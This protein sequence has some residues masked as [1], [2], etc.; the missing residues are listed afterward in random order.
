MFFG[1]SGTSFAMCFVI[2]GEG[3]L[4]GVHLIFFNFSIFDVVLYII[5]VYVYRIL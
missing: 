2:P 5:K 4:K 3:F 1:N